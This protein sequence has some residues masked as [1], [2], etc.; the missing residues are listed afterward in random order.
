MKLH[1]RFHAFSLVEV[2]LAIG[3]AV[4][5]LLAIFALLPVGLNTNQTSV[6][7]TIAAGLAASV[8][9]DISAASKGGQSP[10]Y[11]IRPD[12]AEETE[13]AL[14]ADGSLV[15]DR[16]D[17]DYKAKISITPPGAGIMGPTQVYIRL[18]WP[19]SAANPGN[20]FETVTAMDRNNL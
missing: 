3:I 20:S 17:A 14:K 19:A 5:C 15:G 10:L 12:A 1:S 13:I 7:Q 8:V 4:F 2:T 16:S 11:K 9:A 6:Q 18:S